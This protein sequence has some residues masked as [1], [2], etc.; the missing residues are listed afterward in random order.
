MRENSFI[1]L[2]VPCPCGDSSDAYNI[3]EDGSGYCFGQC[4]GKNFK[5]QKDGELMETGT[6]NAVS[7]KQEYLEANYGPEQ[8]LTTAYH[9][10]RGL[11]ESTLRFYDIET[12]FIDG[13]PLETRFPYLRGSKIKSFENSHKIRSQGDMKNPDLFGMDKFDAGSKE[14]ITITAGEHDAPSFWQITN[15]RTAAVSLPSGST[16]QAVKCVI[17]HRDYINSFKRIILALDNDHVDQATTREI[18]QLFDFNKVYLVKF[19]RHKDANDYLQNNDGSALYSVWDSAK[20]YSPDNII[21]SFQDIEK[22]LEH[23]QEDQIGTYPFT[24]LNQMTYGIHK[25]EI[26]VFKGL[27]K[28]GKTEVLRAL[29][30]HLLKTTDLNI[31][32]IFLEEDNGTTIK[33]IAGYELDQPAML[34]DCGLSAKDIMD[35]YKSA[36]GLKDDRIHLYQSFD[37]EDE[38]RFY[39]SIRFLAA[40]AKCK[41]ILFDH[42]SWLGT[43]LDNDDERKKLDRISQKLKLLAKE[44]EIAIVMISHVNDNGQTRGSRNITKVANT[45]IH[46]DRDKTHSDPIIRNTTYLTLEGVRLGGQTGPAGSVTMDPETRK[47]KEY[48][49]EDQLDQPI[50]HQWSA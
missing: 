4:G 1:K 44:L 19:S 3:R 20:R 12:K 6:A 34:P 22:A 47:L 23:S 9:P 13:V 14:S 27:E 36:V 25:G 49:P 38:Q 31:G 32:I 26:V 28:I 2:H 30:H 11:N 33:G 42:I 7:E 40:G 50:K 15:G 5:K 37:T 21:S 10:H 24:Q 29:A 46:M 8:K 18:S 35:G 16:V 39:D 48:R 45:I 43:G 41:I 17:K